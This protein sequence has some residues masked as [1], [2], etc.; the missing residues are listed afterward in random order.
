[1]SALSARKRFLDT[2]WRGSAQF[3]HFVD[4]LERWRRPEQVLLFDG[5][6][7]VFVAEFMACLGRPAYPDGGQDCG[8]H[9]SHRA[10]TWRDVQGT[11]YKG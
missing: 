7:L 9:V 11:G 5:R 3:W 2:N 8:R 4:A 1:M 10:V 6:P